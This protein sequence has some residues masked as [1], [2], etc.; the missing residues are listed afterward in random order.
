M[1]SVLVCA[2]HR[3]ETRDLPLAI[4]RGWP[5]RI[6]F[7][8]LRQ[9]VEGMQ[10]SLLE[11]VRQDRGTLSHARQQSIFWTDLCQAIDS[12]GVAAASNLKRKGDLLPG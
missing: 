3:F 1:K 6:D 7:R 8:L 9:R 11:L 4:S 5:T 2:R 12:I 10:S